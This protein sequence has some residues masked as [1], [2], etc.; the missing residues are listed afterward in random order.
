MSDGSDSEDSYPARP[1]SPLM[2]STPLLT[3]DD[4]DLLF[5]G[6]SSKI[7]RAHV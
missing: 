2:L 5:Q 7:G 6:T 4:L 1:P 3:F